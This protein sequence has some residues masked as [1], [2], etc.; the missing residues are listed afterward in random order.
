MVRAGLRFYSCDGYRDQGDHRQRCQAEVDVYVGEQAALGDYVILEE[1]ERA[2]TGNAGRA[3]IAVNQ[4]GVLREGGAGGGVEAVG[5][6]QE[7]RGM[8]GHAAIEHDRGG[9][10][11][12]SVS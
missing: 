11:T 12:E 7:A 5:D 8:Q 3:A 1:L 10:N 2:E 4:F 6:V 9:G